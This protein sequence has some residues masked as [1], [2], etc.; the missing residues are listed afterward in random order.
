MNFK[1]DSLNIKDHIQNRLD[2]DKISSIVND[3]KIIKYILI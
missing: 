1:E 3:Y 2:K